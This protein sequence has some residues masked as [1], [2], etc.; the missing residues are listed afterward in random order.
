[1][2]IAS[3][4]YTSTVSFGC[5]IRAGDVECG[6]V[7]NGR[8]GDTEN[9]HGENEL[10]GSCGRASGWRD[11]VAAELLTISVT[12]SGASLD[13]MSVSSPAAFDLPIEK[14]DCCRDPGFRIGDQYSLDE[15]N[16]GLTSPLPIQAGNRE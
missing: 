13:E 9:G 7:E 11:C 16:C 4:T 2:K 5:G 15:G 12:G 1:M 3:A 8:V 14:R 6:P 10:L